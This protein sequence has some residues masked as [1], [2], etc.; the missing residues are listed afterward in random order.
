MHERKERDAGRVGAQRA[1]A[2]AHGLE[3]ARFAAANTQRGWPRLDANTVRS[4]QHLYLQQ[5]AYGTSYIIGK[6]QIEDLLAARRRQLGDAFTIKRFMDEL[7]AIGL[8]PAALV[9]REMTGEKPP[10]LTR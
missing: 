6:I 3:A 4:E 10:H 5:P 1:R 2:R 7:N 8:I 9:P